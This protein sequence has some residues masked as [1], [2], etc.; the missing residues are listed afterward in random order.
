MRKGDILKVRV[1]RLGAQGDGLSHVE[2]RPLYVPLALP[3]E[4]IEVRL[5]DSL[6]DGYQAELLQVI[7]PSPFRVEP[8]CTHFNQCGG[9]SVQHLV[10]AEY[11][12]WK[13]QNVR[14]VLHRARLITN[15][16]EKRIVRKTLFVPPQKRRRITLTAEERGPVKLPILGF[17]ARASHRLIEV[18]ECPVSRPELIAL[19]PALRESLAPWVRAAKTLDISLTLAENGIDILITGS[20]PNLEAREG[21][22][23]LLSQSDVC[24]IGW[25]ANERRTSE[26]IACVRE[27]FVT[28]GGVR[29][30]LPHASFLQP[31]Q[32]GESL[33]V[34]AILEGVCSVQPSASSTRLKCLDLF[35][36]VGSFTFP[37]LNMGTVKAFEGSEDSIQ[38]LNNAAKIANLS[39]SVSGE[40]RDIFRD[41]LTASALDQ[42][43][44]VVIDPPRAGAVAQCAELARSDV[45]L[46]MMVSCNP[47]TF[48][49]DAA[50]LVEGG[51]QLDWVQPIDQFLWSHHI[52]L[53]ARFYRPGAGPT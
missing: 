18:T 11:L 29:V 20:A 37:L 12:A 13:T 50:Q 17:N 1:E 27:P 28:L 38:A 5:L 23:S 14:D 8:Y 6:G 35:S 44:V 48:A 16:N 3:D 40:T 24:R 51:Y 19:F 22:A 30:M 42:Y 39:E 26:A 21:V 43:D 41:P 49:R 36:G 53:V 31:S 33:L 46:V 32:E 9:C 7:E 45:P 10:R 34:K 25:R 15:E 2:R 47:G 4:V 52:E